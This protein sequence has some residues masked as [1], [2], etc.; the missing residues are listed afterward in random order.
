MRLLLVLTVLLF[1]GLN[2]W[3]DDTRSRKLKRKPRVTAV[4][5]MAIISP[6]DTVAAPPAE[7]V[8]LSG[9]DKPLRATAETMFVTNRLQHDIVSISLSITYLDMDDHQLHQRDV[10]VRN[11]IPAGSTRQIKVKSWDSQK[12]FYYHRGQK[13]R[14]DAVTPYKVNCVV[15]SCVIDTVI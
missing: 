14:V 9:Y 13:P 11:S 6:F 4:D 12:S 8:V 7:L 2:G 1:I 15:N 5:T 3:G 10:V